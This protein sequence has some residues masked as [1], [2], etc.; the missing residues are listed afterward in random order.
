MTVMFITTFLMA[1]VIAFVWQ[2]NVAYAALFLVSFWFIEGIYLSAAI[3]KVPDG[4]WVSILLAF[5]LMVVMYVWHYGTRKKYNHDLHNKV[6]L[7]W[8]LGLGP[9]LGIVCVPV[10]G[11]IYSELGTGVP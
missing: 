9:S 6:S 10:I 5:V 1:L 3:M 8:L 11:L 7:K 4:G 2:K